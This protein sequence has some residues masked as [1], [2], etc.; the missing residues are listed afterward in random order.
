[1]VINRHMVIL[2]DI[3]ILIC[4]LMNHS[5]SNRN[6]ATLSKFWKKHYIPKNIKVV[7]V[8]VE[9]E[10]FVKMV[11]KYFCYPASAA[12][13]PLIEAPPSDNKIITGG[14]YHVDIPEMENA[15]VVLGLHSDGFISKSTHWSG[16]L[17]LDMVV[18][19]LLNT[20]LGGGSMFSAGG[21]GKGMY[22]RL[23]RVGFVDII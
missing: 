16:F 22:S 6:H 11:E 15:Y 18:N 7:G 3:R 1:M 9:H 20:I 17:Y 4:T 2:F 5:L 10:K 21:P 13:I 12:N 23:Y 8:G 14:S 19:S